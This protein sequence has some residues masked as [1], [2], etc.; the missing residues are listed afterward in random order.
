M[1]SKA[2]VFSSKFASLFNGLIID[3][4][5]SIFFLISSIT[6]SHY[7]DARDVRTSYT[8]GVFCWAVA[9]NP[10]PCKVDIHKL[11]CNLFAGVKIKKPPTKA[12][13]FEKIDE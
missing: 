13:G 6:C 4:A 1:I 2:F 11:K 8:K 12:R 10:I 7:K 5:H 9:G 3:K